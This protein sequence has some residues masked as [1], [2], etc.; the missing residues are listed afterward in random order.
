MRLGTRTLHNVQRLLRTV[1]AILDLSAL[2]AGVQ[3]YQLETLSLGDLLEDVVTDMEPL[4]WAAGQELL[5][6]VE[7][8]LEP[9]EGDDEKLYRVMVNLIDNAVK[10]SEEGQIQV[11]ATAFPGQP[12]P[13]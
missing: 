4:A 3:R 7:Q 9:V 6:Q 5:L 13:R 1:E 2:E 8:N 11:A 10:F 12:C